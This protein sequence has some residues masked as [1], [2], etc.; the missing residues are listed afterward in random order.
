MITL[1]ILLS[2]LVSGHV[3]AIHEIIFVLCVVQIEGQAVFFYLNRGLHLEAECKASIIRIEKF[4]LTEEFA[5]DVYSPRMLGSSEDT[6]RNNG[7]D[8]PFIDLR[9]LSCGYKAESQILSEVT[10]HVQGRE[11]VAVC[12]AV[13]C[14]K[15]SLRQ[16]MLKELPIISGK[17]YHQGKIAYV[18][19]VPWVFSGTV[20]ENILFYHSLDVERLKTV[21]EACGLKSDIATFPDGDLTI[22]G[23]NGVVL[24]GGQRARVSLARAVYADADIY[25]LDDPLRAVD[26]KVGRQ[27]FEKCIIGIMK[28][29]LRILVTHNRQCLQHADHVI[30]LEKGRVVEHQSYSGIIQSDVMATSP[31]T[32]FLS[33]DNKPDTS[34]TKYQE[35]PLHTTEAVA[36]LVIPEEDRALGLVSWKTYWCYISAVLPDPLVILLIL[37][38][39]IASGKLIAIVIPYTNAAL[40]RFCAK[41]FNPLQ[42]QDEMS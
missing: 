36:S 10:L 24:S 38:L 4:L 21:I 11:F 41:R 39:I 15:S 20:R 35:Y 14:G 19:Q 6:C 42:V 23:E 1:S 29:R 27:I 8:F 28:T 26:A 32:S 34:Q 9:N 5:G 16:A 22:I 30:L 31:V 13:G 33:L 40:V 25:L 3:L 17:S 12:G 2:L 18:P 37:F 7:N